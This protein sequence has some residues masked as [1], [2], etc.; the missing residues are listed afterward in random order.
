MTTALYTHDSSKRHVTPP[1][2]PERVARIEAVI[3]ALADLDDLDRRVC[4]EGAREDVQRCH[5][6]RYIARVAAAVPETGFVSLDADTHLSPGSLDAALFAVGG[7]AAAVDA[8]IG[9]EVGNALVACRPPG[10]HAER[11]RAM[12]FCFLSNAAIGALHALEAHGLSRV[13]VVDFDVH[14]GNGSQD[15]FEADPRVLYVSSHEWPLYPGTGAAGEVG[16]G[17]IVNLCLPSGS[18]GATFRAAWTAQ[19]LP[20]LDRFAPELLIVSAG[21]DAHA[22]DPLATLRLGVDDFAWITHA[23]CD[24]AAAHCRGRIVSTLEGGY[25]L[26]ALARSTAAHVKVLAERS[27]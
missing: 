27:A 20:A 18:D 5:P 19:G 10:H 1:G 3:A 2:H 7:M 16:V 17:N 9:G 26:E 23:L 12:G 13:A 6:A 22:R 24:I 11:A 8:V 15:V 21:F 25:D 4:P 14:H